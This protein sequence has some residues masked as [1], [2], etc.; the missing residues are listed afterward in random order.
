MSEKKTGKKDF[1]KSAGKAKAY[2]KAGRYV[3]EIGGQRLELETVEDLMYLNAAIQQVM[4]EEWRELLE[5]R[6]AK[7]EVTYREIRG[8]EVVQEY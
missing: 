7:G 3:I 2:R 8:G 5:E 4:D 1:E 6:K